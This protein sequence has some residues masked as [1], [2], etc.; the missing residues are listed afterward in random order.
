MLLTSTVL[1]VTEIVNARKNTDWHPK[2]PESLFL[3]TRSVFLEATSDENDACVVIFANRS[4]FS[5]QERKLTEKQ[6]WQE[7]V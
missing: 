1:F 2:T 5:R 6:Q 3:L 7:G 4:V